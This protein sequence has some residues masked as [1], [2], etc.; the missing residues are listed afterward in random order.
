MTAGGGRGKLYFNYSTMNAGKSTS[1]LQASWNYRERGMA[2][3]M[4]TAKLDSRAGIGRIS[5]RIGDLPEILLRINTTPTKSPTPHYE[6]QGTLAHLDT[7]AS[8]LMLTHLPKAM[9]CSQGC[10][11]RW[12]RGRSMAV[13]LRASSL[14]RRNF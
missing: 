3:Y 12:C 6:F 10:V 9:T 13:R 5:S 4:L 14:T 2:T 11:N 1:L 7:Q 8:G